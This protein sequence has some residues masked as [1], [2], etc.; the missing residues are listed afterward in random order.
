MSNSE[1]NPQSTEAEQQVE[2]SAHTEIIKTSEAQ[3]FPPACTSSDPATENGKAECQRQSS[4][5]EE[6]EEEIEN[7]EVAER[8]ELIPSQ[9]LLSDKANGRVTFLDG[10]EEMREAGPESSGPHKVALKKELT[11]LNG[12]AFVVGQIIGSGIFITPRI[13]L[14]HTH[15]VML[16]L[17]MWVLGGVISLWGALCYCELGTFVKK[18]GGE[19][20]YLLEAYTFKRRKP[21]LEFVGSLLAFLYLWSSMLVVRPAGFAVITLAT[22]RY[23]SGALY[24]DS[25]PPAYVAKLLAVCAIVILVI[26]NCY[27][28]RWSAWLMTILSLIKVISCVFIVCLGGWELVRNRCFPRDGCDDSVVRGDMHVTKSAGDVALALYGVLMAYDG[29]NVLNYSVEEQE[30]ASKNLPRA[31]WIGLPIVAVCYI[32][33]SMSFF[34]AVGSEQILNGGPVALEFGEAMLGTPGAILLSILVALSAFGAANGSLFAGTRVIFTSARDGIFPKVLSGVHVNFNTPVPATLS[35]VPLTLV[36]LAMGSIED[37]ID[38]M[39]AAIWV[40]YA[41]TFAAVL[42]MRVTHHK[43]PRPYRVHCHCM[44][45]RITAFI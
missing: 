43:D 2:N 24:V 9:G 4:L 35:S 29:W 16:S 45:H 20:T 25:E 31:I 30:N 36:Y 28:V 32:L 8:R 18:S 11:L 26:V 13:I 39:S 41:L 15:S 37:L 6:D 12:V 42:V 34:A 1:E 27:S 10:E 38:G 3:A 14:G 22:G 7:S 44:V 5:A 23:L 40:F 33:V 19:Y 17:A 21:F